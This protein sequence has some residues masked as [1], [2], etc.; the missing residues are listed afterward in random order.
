M[1]HQDGRCA[2]DTETIYADNNTAVCAPSTCGTAATPCCDP[3]AAFGALS[4]T[5]RLIVIR[6]TAKGFTYGGSSL[7][8]QVTVVGQNTANLYP[9]P[10]SAYLNCVAISNG[11]DVYMRDF[12]CN[13]N[14]NVAGVQVNSATIHLLRAVIFNSGGGIALESSNF[15]IIDTILSN[16]SSGDLGGHAFGGI[17][18]DNPPATGLKLLQRITLKDINSP[19]DIGCSSGPIT[20]SGIYAPDNKGISPACGITTCT[21]LSATCGSDLN[22]T[23]PNH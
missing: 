5:R 3:Q 10:S 13:T 4:A 22:W 8:S 15:E 9:D 18:V 17:Y 12:Q 19:T 23:S 14:Y 1:S 21:A 2:T 11:A 7:G 6:G 20:S 16:N